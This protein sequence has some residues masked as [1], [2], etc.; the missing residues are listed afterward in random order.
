V[1]R[2]VAQH[3]IALPAPAGSQV[4]VLPGR[5]RVAQ[6]TNSSNMRVTRAAVRA[7]GSPC[8]R[9]RAPGGALN[10]NAATNVTVM[11]SVLLG[12]EAQNGGG[13]CIQTCGHASFFDNSFTSNWADKSGGGLFQLKCSGA[14]R[15]SWGPTLRPQRPVLPLHVDTM[16]VNA[17]AERADIGGEMHVLGACINTVK[18]PLVFRSRP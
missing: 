10:L 3:C 11:S 8:A 6:A 1:Q 4:T 15:A 13:V 17:A 9:P 16:T 2:P 12:N 18:C 5:R 7:S 14:P